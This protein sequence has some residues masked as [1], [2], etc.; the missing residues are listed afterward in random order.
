M[1][2][3]AIIPARD[4]SKRI[5]NKNLLKINNKTI[6]EINYSNLKKTKIFHK[7]ILSTESNRIK[8]LSKE[9]GFDYVIDRPKNLSKDDTSTASVISHAIKFLADKI[10]FTHVCCIYPMA[11]LIEKNDLLKAK[12]IIKKKNEIIFPALK[13]SHPIQRAFKIN[14][15]SN[16]KYNIPHKLLSRKTQ[17]FSEYFHD[18]GQFYV[19]YKSAW[20]YFN[21]SKKKC[22]EI[23]SLRAV[24]VDNINDFKL[25]KLLYLSK[26]K[27]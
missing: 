26:N 11:I 13:Y 19:G 24:D 10:D 15:N 7:I 16:I 23:E 21:R 27:I 5:K 20:K 6:L 22:F 1:K 25:L 18:A 4:N 3:I 17:S 12:Q 14:K 9:I 8:R 2:I